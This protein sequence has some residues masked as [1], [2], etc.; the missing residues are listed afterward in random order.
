VEWV[1]LKPIAVWDSRVIHHQQAMPHF[2]PFF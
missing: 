1:S 2:Q